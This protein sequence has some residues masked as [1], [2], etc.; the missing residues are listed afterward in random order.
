MHRVFL[1]KLKK[2]GILI[3][4][5]SLNCGFPILRERILALCFLYEPC[6]FEFAEAASNSE[7]RLTCFARDF[8]WS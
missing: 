3:N 2:E 8:F 7:Q 5:A 1:A 4:E 6:I